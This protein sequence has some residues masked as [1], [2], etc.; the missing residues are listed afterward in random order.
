M[1]VQQEQSKGEAALEGSR[2]KRREFIVRSTKL[3]ACSTSRT[4]IAP[5]LEDGGNQTRK[6]KS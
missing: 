5:K 3:S 2:S 6:N 1:F 4:L